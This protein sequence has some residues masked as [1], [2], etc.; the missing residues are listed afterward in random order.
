MRWVRG[1]RRVRRVRQVRQ[2]RATAAESA[3]EE[4]TAVEEI[5]T[6]LRPPM[7]FHGERSGRARASM[8]LMRI[9][10]FSKLI[11][12]QLARE[13]Q[14]EVFTITSKPEFDRNFDLRNQLRDAASSARRNIAEGFGRRTHRDI[15]NFFNLSL[16]SVSEVEGELGEA[17][18]N[19]YVTTEE[20]GRALNLCKRTCV[21]TSRFRNSLKARPDPPWNQWPNRRT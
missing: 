11:C 9:D 7:H 6:H 20:I 4:M 19:K 12:W 1:V 10:H 21:A 15:A 8:L 5:S 2:V 17:V 14:Q 18:D 3:T 16:A 13:L